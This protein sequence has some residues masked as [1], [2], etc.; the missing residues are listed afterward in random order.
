[1][2]SADRGWPS[3]FLPLL[4]VVL[5]LHGLLVPA[6][7]EL[8]VVGTDLLGSPFTTGLLDAGVRA[9]IALR[10]TLD[11]SLPGLTQLQAGSADLGL[12]LLHPG[13][14][15]PPASLR[16]VPLAYLA[17]AVAVHDENPLATISLG[18]LSSVFGTR[19]HGSIQRWSELGVGEPLLNRPISIYAPASTSGL[20][21]DLFQHVVLGERAFRESLQLHA[22]TDELIATAASNPGA[23]AV[24]PWPPA[25]TLRGLKLVRISKDSGALSFSPE[26]TALHRGDYPLRL[27]LWLVF[28]DEV[29][30]EL[31]P[32]LRI[33][34]SDQGAALLAE[35]GL[36]AVPPEIRAEV[37]Q[38]L[39]AALP[40]YPAAAKK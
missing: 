24:I 37:I 10:V 16:V 39:T 21:H 40:L 15:P 14:P 34:L 23:L 9:R 27:P 31:T 29:R 5:F 4:S 20:A 7:A 17:V 11:G 28:R 18:Q 26:A 32:L 25:S 13:A 30:A 3:A 6:R 8:K 12:F 33:L 35:A 19:T 1:M 22:N 38:E 36:V 2:S